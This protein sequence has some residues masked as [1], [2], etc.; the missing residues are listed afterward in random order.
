MTVALLGAA[1]FTAIV[2][3]LVCVVLVARAWLQPGGEAVVCV[4]RERNVLAP[5]GTKLLAALNAASI[6]IPSGCGG[7]GTCGQCRIRVVEGGG[8][9]L[10]M[11]TA[12]LARREV[13]QGVRLA[14]QVTV[15]DDLEVAIPEDVLGVQ[16][17]RC[18]VAST[19]CVGTFIKEIVLEMPEGEGI[20]A[21][22]GRYVLVT[23]PPY[24]LSYRDLA[25]D[26][27]VRDEWD[28]LDLWRLTASNDAPTTRAYSMANHPGEKGTVML[29][30]RIATPPP[31]APTAPPGVASSWLFGLRAGD[32]VDIAGPYGHFLVEPGDSELVFVGGG[33]GMAPMRAHLFDQ[34]EHL[35][36][37]RSMS[38]WYG[39]RSR[40][41]LFYVEDFDRLAATHA[42]FSWTP[43]LSEP[44]PEDQWQGETGFVHEVLLRRHLADHP[45]P[46]T[47]EY[48]LCGPPLMVKA[49]R[50]LLDELGVDP[51]RVHAD[52]FGA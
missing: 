7:K 3:T 40:R 29:I 18:R 22:A 12:I 33:A 51:E 21:P 4:N 9:P 16:H 46:E 42:N 34:L 39:A 35:R 14:C 28:R 36:S 27:E 20:D 31:A 6:E 44:R 50:S 2:M 11:E 13:A 17:W 5:R 37:S 47:C 45:A 25:V 49:V 23:C 32:E 43:A 48:Y 38:F 24:R 1:L 15:R 30:V 10:P 41:E 52:D 8:P 19:R 26:P